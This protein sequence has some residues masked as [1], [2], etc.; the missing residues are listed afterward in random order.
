MQQILIQSIR[1]M[2]TAHLAQTMT[3]MSLTVE[4]LQQEIDTVLASNPALELVDERRCPTCHRLLNGKR[5]L[6]YLQC[7]TECWI[8]HDPVVFISPSEDFYISSESQ[9][10]YDREDDYTVKEED[11]TGYVLRQIGPD[12]N[13]KERIIAAYLLTNLDEDGFITVQPIGNCTIFSCSSIH[14]R[15]GQKNNS[16]GRSDW[17]W[18]NKSQRGIIGPN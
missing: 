2:T 10:D 7:T 13:P 3:L 12:L 4:E 16:E 9:E 17:C 6:S 14:S 18:F 1:P 8:K 15:R 5:T 11:L